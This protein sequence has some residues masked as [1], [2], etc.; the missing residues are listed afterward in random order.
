MWRSSTPDAAAEAAI[1]VLQ[2]RGFWGGE[3]WYEA[4]SG[5][6][7]E[8]W[9]ATNTSARFALTTAPSQLDRI[10]NTVPQI[11]LFPRQPLLDDVIEIPTAPGKRHEPVIKGKGIPVW[12]L[13]SYVTKRHMSAEEVSNLWNGY[14]TPAEVQAAV[15][16]SRLHPEEVEDKLSDEG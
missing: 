16:F 4:V 13:V 9:G 8:Y 10:L 2:I 11:S 3:A 5:Y 6:L 1:C 12:V 7:Q 14:V 15:A